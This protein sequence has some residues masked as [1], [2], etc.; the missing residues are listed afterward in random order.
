VVYRDVTRQA[1][2]LY[3]LRH[4]GAL[5][6]GLANLSRYNSGWFCHNKDI[7]QDNKTQGLY[8]VTDSDCPQH[9]TSEGSI[10]GPSMLQQMAQGL[11][12]LL[13]T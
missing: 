3:R 1:K 2:G 8:Y 7:G 9:P 11:S 13:I 5:E 12:K 10:H 4:V 6:S